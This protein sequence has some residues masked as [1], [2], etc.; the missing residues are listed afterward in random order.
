MA[1]SDIAIVGLQAIGGVSQIVISW[2]FDD[3]NASGLPY[4]R[5]KKA[6][7]QYS[8]LADMS[9]PVSLGFA[10]T[11]LVDLPV[12][13]GE[14]RYYRSR[15]IDQSDQAGEWS[16]VASA[17]EISFD[18]SIAQNGYWKL[19]NGLIFQWGLSSLSDVNG[20]AVATFPIQFPGG[21]LIAVATTANNNPGLVVSIGLQ[22]LTSSYAEFRLT[23]VFEG[24]GLVL[25]AVSGAPCWW[26][27]VGY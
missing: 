11:A 24:V 9:S 21:A 5:F 6:E 25:S 7:V 2:S 17:R 10:S 13:R 16:A 26:F 15:A 19:P 22:L 4:L 23:N 14:Y 27:A 12:P 18:I 20:T 1:D 3:P 8:H